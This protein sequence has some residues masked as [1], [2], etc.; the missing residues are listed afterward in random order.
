MSN[1]PEQFDP[2]KFL[3]RI[4]DPNA[5]DD[6]SR[7]MLSDSFR[8]TDLSTMLKTALIAVEMLAERVREL[9]KG[10]AKSWPT[11]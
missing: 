10:K 1:E 5:S 8:A 3:N 7:L 6:E 11:P 4:G 2:H 9:E